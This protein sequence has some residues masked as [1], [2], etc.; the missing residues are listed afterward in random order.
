MLEHIRSMTLKKKMGIAAVVIAS[1]AYLAS[2]L[3]PPEDTYRPAPL[4][5]NHRIV[6]DPRDELS[7]VVSD[8]PDAADVGYVVGLGDAAYRSSKK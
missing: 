2:T 6:G 8:A 3:Q 1:C 5:E 7:D 4:T